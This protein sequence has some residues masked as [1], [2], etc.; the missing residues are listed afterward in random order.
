MDP[1]PIREFGWQVQRVIERNDLSREETRAVFGEILRNEQPEL[2]QG[3]LLAALAAK[4]ETAEEIAGAWEAI[5]A[6]DTIAATDLEA[7]PLVENSGTGM[8]QLKTF[9][10]STAAA[11]IAATAGARLARHGARGLTSACGTVDVLE[12]LGLD[13]DCPVP[14]VVRS[15]N[16]VGIGLFNGMSATV[17]PGALG[18]ILAQI[19]FGSTLNIAASLASPCRATHGL[20]GVHRADAIHG[21]VEVMKAIGYRRAM[22]V[23]GW[24][25][26]KSHGM[27]EL[28]T[29]GDTEVA[30]LHES[31]HVDSYVLS[32]E[33]LGLERSTYE[34][35]ATSGDVAIEAER[36][37]QLLSGLGT[38]AREDLACLNA[39]AILYLVKLA[40]SLKD[41]ITLARAQLGSA[42]LARL[43]GWVRA[44]ARDV[45]R[46]EIAVRQFARVVSRAGVPA[47]LS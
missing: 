22:V 2:Q 36:M 24:D 38:K 14:Q 40:P 8:D 4:G 20:R 35:V 23:H 42:A 6:L 5:V 39:G 29:L 18:R 9:N 10:V 17:H 28:S 13:I 19:R 16:T 11:I 7:G 45:M 33:S 34:D 37:V 25:A 1:D 27:D 46:Q 44:Q 31:G 43:E 12:A 21:V 47:H 3:A 32:P 15:I 41:G 30:E 26:D